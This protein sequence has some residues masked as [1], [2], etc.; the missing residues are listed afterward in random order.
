MTVTRRYS[1]DAV[2]VDDDGIYLRLRKVEIPVPPEEKLN[3]DIRTVSE[4][5]DG[6]KDE[7]VT[8]MMR[9]A[10]TAF[11]DVF[12]TPMLTGA[13]RESEG[14]IMGITVS[15]EEWEALGRPSITDVLEMV[16]SP[17]GL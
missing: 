8:R 1:V 10:V 3:R 15:V 9:M 7:E 5:M 13:H 17:V 4:V 12:P 16:W 14:E 11:K 2:A 6:N